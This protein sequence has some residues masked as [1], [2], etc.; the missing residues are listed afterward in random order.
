MI[1][2]CAEFPF[3]IMFSKLLY[4]GFVPITWF[5]TAGKPGEGGLPPFFFGAKRKK[6]NKGK[7]ACYQGQNVTVFA[8]LEG[9]EFKYFSSGSVMVVSNTF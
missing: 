7:K 3:K 8:I 6:G 1:L 9:L 5:A 4:Y 2:S